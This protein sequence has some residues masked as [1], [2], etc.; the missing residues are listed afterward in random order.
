SAASEETR[1]PD[2]DLERRGPGWRFT[3]R[4]AYARWFPPAE[5]S[6][7]AACVEA[8][9][10]PL[11]S[12]D[13]TG[14]RLLERSAAAGAGEQRRSFVFKVYRYPFWP[15][16]R[17]WLRASKAEQEFRNLLHLQRLGVPAVE[18]VGFGLE[19]SRIGFVRSCFVITCYAGDTV[20]LRDWVRR[21]GEAAA[22]ASDVARE[23]FR[24][25]GGAFRRLHEGRFFLFS[26]KA[27]NILMRARE[28]EPPE[29]MFI[30]IPYA[31]SQG[32]GVFDRWAQSRD[33]G[34]FFSTFLPGAEDSERAPFYE[35]YLPDPLGGSAEALKREVAR[36][37]RVNQNRTLISGLVHRAK[38]RLRHRRRS[39]AR[40]S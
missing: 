25:V 33:I 38:K 12:E 31:R 7:Y 28:G 9:G 11:K 32:W 3:V 18:P 36:A 27:K 22:R 23:V 34:L 20:H 14:V 19:R 1:R 2:G 17:T 16:L 37:V 5:F 8:R 10:K 24:Q 21:E 39:A 26:A 6:D 13:R 4:G 30:D 15:R 40:S 29:L 35:A